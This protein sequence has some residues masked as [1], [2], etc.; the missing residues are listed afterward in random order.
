M[1]AQSVTSSSAVRRAELCLLSGIRAFY[2]TPKSPAKSVEAGLARH[3]AGGRLGVIERGP[4]S[5]GIA[6]IADERQKRVAVAGRA[7]EALLENRHGVLDV[8]GRVQPDGVDIRVSCSV[9]IEFG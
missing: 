8:P 6:A 4:K 5:P 2:L 7:G 1:L 9:G 3:I